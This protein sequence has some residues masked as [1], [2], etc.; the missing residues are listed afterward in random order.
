MTG[1]T[2]IAVPVLLDTNTQADSLIQQWYRLYEQGHLVAPALSVATATLYLSAAGS[3]FVASKKWRTYTAAGIL[4]TIMIPFTLTVMAPTNN[5][6]FLLERNRETVAMATL[7]HVRY[8]VT[9]WGRLHL[10][11]SLFPMI[12]SALGMMG[13]LREVR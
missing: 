8:L 5:E 12:G 9:T 13:L 2:V 11:R 1:L 10:V 7:D 4:T 6:L 3:R